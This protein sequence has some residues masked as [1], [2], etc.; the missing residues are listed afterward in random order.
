MAFIIGIIYFTKLSPSNKNPSAINQ[1]LKCE[2]NVDS[3]V[4]TKKN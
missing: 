1:N 4:L 2:L 3:E